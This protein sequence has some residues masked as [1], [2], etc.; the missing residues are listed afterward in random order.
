MDGNLFAWQAKTSSKLFFSSAHLDAIRNLDFYIFSDENAVFPS[1]TH[2]NLSA[3]LRRADKLI[4]LLSP[5]F[6]LFW[7]TS[8]YF[9]IFSVLE[10]AKFSFVGFVTQFLLSHKLQNNS[11][12]FLNLN[13]AF[14]RYFLIYFLSSN[15]RWIFHESIFLSSNLH[16]I[17]LHFSHFFHSN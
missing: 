4:H 13:E 10:I 11:A 3:Q 7:A 9:Q 1:H 5:L 15:F 16:F 6:T 8:F 12:H 17:S 14:A 2:L